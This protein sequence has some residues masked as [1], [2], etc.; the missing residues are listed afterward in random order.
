MRTDAW[1]RI[2]SLL[3]ALALLLAATA[4]GGQTP[5]PTPTES[6]AVSDAQP[7]ADTAALADAAAYILRT[8]PEPQ[9]SSVGGEWAVLG[10]ARSGRVRAEWFESYFDNLT[11]LVRAQEGVLHTRKYTEYARV[12]LALTAVGKDPRD[13]G[14][15]DLLTPLGDFDRVTFQGLNGA[16]FAL[17]ALDAGGYAVPDAPAGQVQATREGYLAEILAYQTPSGG[18]ALDADGG[19][20]DVDI[21]AMALCALAPYCDD[22]AAADAARKALLWLSDAQGADGDYGSAESNAQV[23]IALAAC[24][25]APE[26]AHFVKNGCSALDALLAY[27]VPGGGYR[28]AAGDAEANPMASEQALLALAAVARQ[29]AGE[30]SLYAMTGNAAAPRLNLDA[31]VGANEKQ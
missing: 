11:A 6:T 31:A 29:R 17:L 22:A 12:V 10:L 24:G 16:V 3:A 18:F 21:T 30:S 19:D 2:C 5:A 1:K 9:C 26:D 14:G 23:L 13:V 7:S 15:Y 20:A 25:I 27:A 8:V 28:H 4:C